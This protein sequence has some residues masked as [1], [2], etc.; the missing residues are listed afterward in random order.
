MPHPY[1]PTHYNH[2]H[3]HSWTYHSPTAWF[4]ASVFKVLDAITHLSYPPVLQDT[5]H[6]HTPHTK[7]RPHTPSHICHPHL[8]TYRPLPSPLPRFPSSSIILTPIPLLYQLSQS[9]SALP[10]VIDAPIMTR[11]RERARMKTRSDIFAD[12][13]FSYI[14]NKT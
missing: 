9:K 14:R 13:N 8:R 12:F 4:I 11:V 1:F 7:P 5:E 3:T 2:T 10:V 6:C